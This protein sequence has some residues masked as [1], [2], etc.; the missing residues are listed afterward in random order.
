MVDKDTEIAKEAAKHYRDTILVKYRRD[1]ITENRISNFLTEVKKFFHV[2]DNV[3]NIDFIAQLDLSMLTDST[4]VVADAKPKNKFVLRQVR[5]F[6]TNR[7]GSY[8]RNPTAKKRR[9]I[10]KLINVYFDSFTVC[11]EDH[12][13]MQLWIEKLYQLSGL[14]L[15]SKMSDSFSSFIQEK[16]NPEINRQR[17]DLVHK[18]E[19]EMD[20]DEDWKEIAKKRIKK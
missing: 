15:E 17:K 8:I 4:R 1:R 16:I 12:E 13:E 5:T 19:N 20:S 9:V 14:G 7:L 18:I 6:I 11:L 3:N 2:L 10:S